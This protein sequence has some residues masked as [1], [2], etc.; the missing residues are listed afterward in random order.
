MN[1]EIIAHIYDT[2]TDG[3]AI[4]RVVTVEDTRTTEEQQ[5]TTTAEHGQQE[6]RFCS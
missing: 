3:A 1:V 4:S 2:S 5:Q 6:V